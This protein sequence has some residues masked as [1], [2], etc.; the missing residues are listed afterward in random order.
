MRTEEFING[1]EL[2]TRKVDWHWSVHLYTR[3]G[4]LVFVSFPRS[5]SAFEMD[6]RSARIKA[7]AL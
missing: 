1:Y 5:P 7:G 6:V 3:R 4:D 2:V